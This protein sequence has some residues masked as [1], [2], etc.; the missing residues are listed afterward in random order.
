MGID[1][2]N[3]LIEECGRVCSFCGPGT[4]ASWDLMLDDGEQVYVCYPDYLAL[5]SADLIVDERRIGEMTWEEYLELRDFLNK[6]EN[7]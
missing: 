3:E 1:L 5:K 7:E 6:Q 2:E 4:F